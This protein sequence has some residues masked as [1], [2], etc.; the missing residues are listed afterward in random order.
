M[1]I[2]NFW[3]WIAKK[4]AIISQEGCWGDCGPDVKPGDLSMIYHKNPKSYI[5]ELALI[6]SDPTPNCQ[7]KTQKG[8][9]KTGHCCEYEII[10]EFRYPLRYVEMNANPI[11]NEWIATNKNLQGM[12]FS[13]DELIWNL[14][15]DRIKEINKNYPGYKRLI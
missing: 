15:E 14:I 9:T 3:F 2:M 11:L 6:T 13:V 1:I 7:I 8:Y 10:H 4:E 12:Y 5:E